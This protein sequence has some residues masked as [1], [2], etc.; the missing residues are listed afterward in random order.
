M[1]IAIALAAAAAL[2]AA[3]CAAEPAPPGRAVRLV[4]SDFAFT[5][6]ELALRQ[7]ELVTIEMPNRGAVDHEIM[8]GKGEI[9][10]EGGYTEDLFAGVDVTLRGNEKPDHSHGGF[11]VLVGKGKTARMTFVVPSRPGTYEM[12]CF[13]PGHYL[14]GMVG[15]I[16]IE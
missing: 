7:G 16:V 13:Q 9:R 3:A 12:G 11:M 8:A 2:V 1:R 15:R 5:P 6:K 4:M 14:A 10:H